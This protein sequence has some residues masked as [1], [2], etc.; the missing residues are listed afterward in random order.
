MN[1]LNDP[2]KTA[3]IMSEFEKQSAK[4]NMTDE[5]SKICVLSV[6]KLYQT[7]YIDIKS[8]THWME[9]LKAVTMRCKATPLSVKF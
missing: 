6:S 9:Y 2:Q 4:M 7:N 5:M 3:K 8:T 1:K